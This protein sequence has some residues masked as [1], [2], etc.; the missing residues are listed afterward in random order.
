LTWD[1]KRIT[2]SMRS[3]DVAEN[4][5]ERLKTTRQYEHGV[6]GPDEHCG[7]TETG[8][9]ETEGFNADGSRTIANA[10]TS[11][12]VAP[13]ASSVHAIGR[14]SISGSAN[15]IGDAKRE[16]KIARHAERRAQNEQQTLSPAVDDLNEGQVHSKMCSTTPTGQSGIDL[17]RDRKLSQRAKRWAAMEAVNASA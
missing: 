15:L 2:V 12:Y 10:G 7:R 8:P 6:K 1:R 9:V 5:R 14:Q 13:E 4:E 17:K 3:E 11:E 16:R